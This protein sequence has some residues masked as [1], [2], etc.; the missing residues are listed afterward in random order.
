VM[1]AAVTL[2]GVVLALHIMAVIAAY[3]LPLAYPM[4]LPYLRR[5]HPGAMPG[6]HDVQHRLNVRLTAPASVLI[7]AFG[8]YMATTRHYW[9][10]GW[11]LV[12]LGL[13]TVISVV[14]A[15]YIVPVSRRMAELARADVSSTPLGV[16]VAWGR[17]YR[18]VYRLYLAIETL[19]GVLVITAIFFM[20]AKPL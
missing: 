2:Y 9:Q 10:E 15:T 20:A 5:T 14:G 8:V 19:L 4:L 1:S 3:G 16:T 12:A 7:V 17:E 18:R 6:I 11:L 13:F